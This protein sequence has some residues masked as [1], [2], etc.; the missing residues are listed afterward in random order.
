MEGN[1]RRWRGAEG[2]EELR[3]LLRP[4]LRAPGALTNTKPKL[5]ELE[6]ITTVHNELHVL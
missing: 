4:G 2:R 1:N 5:P 3:A 6:E